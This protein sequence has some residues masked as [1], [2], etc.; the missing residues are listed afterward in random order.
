MSDA[1]SHSDHA[2]INS[3]NSNKL[4]FIKKCHVL[5]LNLSFPEAIIN[6]K[7]DNMKPYKNAACLSYA[8][9]KTK[10]SIFKI[11]TFTFTEHRWNMNGTSPK[12]IFFNSFN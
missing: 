6:L 5:K 9:S 4:K 11:A 10:K 1:L 2:V 3:Y 8:F 12:K 7:N